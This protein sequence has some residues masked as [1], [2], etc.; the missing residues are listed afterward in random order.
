MLVSKGNLLGKYVALN[1]TRRVVIVIIQTAFTNSYHLRILYVGVDDLQH[2]VE[3]F[4]SIVGMQ[5]SSG[6]D[7][8]VPLS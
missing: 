3:P 1:L 6:P 8:F 5:A 4:S 2:R 7:L